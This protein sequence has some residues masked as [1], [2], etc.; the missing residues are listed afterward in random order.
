[1]E[2]LRLI[3]F[4][5]LFLFR[6]IFSTLSDKFSADKSA[7]NLACCRKF[8]PPNFFVRRKFY[9][10]RYWSLDS[11]TLFGYNSRFAT[12]LHKHFFRQGKLIFEPICQNSLSNFEVKSK[13]RGSFSCSFSHKKMCSTYLSAAVSQPPGI[14]TVV[15]KIFCKCVTW[16][17]YAFLQ[18]IAK[19][20]VHFF[21][22]WH[23]F[24][25]KIKR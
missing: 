25:W 7:E 12:I 6:E 9:P 19:I 23:T 13:T 15:L 14:L 16:H 10:T 24:S 18:L 8:C 11:F 21:G 4:E 5:L 2:L 20:R 22:Y 1:M 17:T 3:N